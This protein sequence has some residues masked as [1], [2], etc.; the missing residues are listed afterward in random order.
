MQFKFS[1]RYEKMIEEG[2]QFGP[3]FEKHRIVSTIHLACFAGVD[4]GRAVT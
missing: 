3:V 2:L 4:Q 1:I